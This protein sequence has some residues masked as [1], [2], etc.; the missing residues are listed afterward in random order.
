MRGYG[1]EELEIGME[2][3]YEREITEELVAQYAELSGDFNPVHMDEEFAKGTRFKGRI[4]HGLLTAS[5]LSTVLGT[6]LPGPGSIY[7]HQDLI[8]RAPVRFG[9][10]VL[11][12]VKVEK[13]NLHRRVVVLSCKCEVKGRAVLQGEAVMMVPSYEKE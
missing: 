7:L 12:S 5:F 3:S 1:I 8:F 10:V 6:K 11:S 13:V 2:A 4:A 9:D